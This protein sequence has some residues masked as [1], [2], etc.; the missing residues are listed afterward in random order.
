MYHR[1]IEKKFFLYNGRLHAVD[2]FDAS[3]AT[4]YPS[5]YEVIRV[6]KG[7]PLFWEAHVDRL[8][9]SLTLAGA[10]IQLDRSSLRHQMELLI[11][12]NQVTN[13]NLKVVVNQWQL[14]ESPDVYVFFIA[15]RYPSK[16][17]LKEG[18]SVILHP[19]ERQNPNAKI[20]STDFRA[21]ILAALETT[22]AY[23]ALLLNQ[24]NEITEGSRSN[25][26]VINNNT[27][28]TPPASQVL[29]GITR[30]VVINLLARLGYLLEETV[31]SA[32]F[33]KKADGLFITGTSPGVLPVKQVDDQPFSVSLEPLQQLQG[34]Y[35]HFVNTYLE[36]HQSMD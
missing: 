3:Q 34:L 33:L 7:L 12:E 13:H 25:F 19:A 10:T 24:S 36:V 4:H 21:P 30:Q 2:K 26:F 29:Q 6:I 14:K 28:Y 9:Q 5:V 27:F 31:I 15:T 22:G 35:H 1:E 32:D 20:I 23:E 8:Q 16:K 11:T 17:A 18:V